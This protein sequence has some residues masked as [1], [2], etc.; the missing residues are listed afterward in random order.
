[1][2]MQFIYVLACMPLKCKFLREEINTFV[3][4]GSV[5]FLK[6]SHVHLLH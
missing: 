5:I 6:V 3:V 2:N 4:I 1:M